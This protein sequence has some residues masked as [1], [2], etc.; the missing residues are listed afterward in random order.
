MVFGEPLDFSRFR[1]MKVDR[2]LLRSVTDEI[3]SEL[4]ALGDQEFRD[5][6]ASG[7]R[8]RLE[9]EAREAKA[10]GRAA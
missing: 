3:M 5:V 1:G 8:S 7:V 10:L 2:F 9:R 6:Y 4:H